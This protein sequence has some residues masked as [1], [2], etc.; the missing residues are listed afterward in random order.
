MG[1]MLTSPED[2]MIFAQSSSAGDL[3]TGQ[4][5]PRRAAHVSPCCWPALACNVSDLYCS[6]M[7][8]CCLQRTAL[9]QLAAVAATPVTCAVAEWATAACR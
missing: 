7:G 1:T 5:R 3:L 9:D 8:N 4:G 2:C 6:S